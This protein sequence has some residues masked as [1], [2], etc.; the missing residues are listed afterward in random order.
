MART[1]RNGGWSGVYRVVA[2]FAAVLMLTA[3]SAQ[4]LVAQGSGAWQALSVYEGLCR[5]A[6][7]AL[8]MLWGMQA[9]EEGKPA[10]SGALGGLALP[11]FCLLVIWGALYAV[12][13][14]LL[15][16]GALSWP[17][18][19]GALKSAALGQTHFHL[20]LLYPLI[21][22]Y[23]IHP[24]LHRF[25]A[26]ASRGEVRYFLILCFVFASLLPVW[27]AFHPDDAVG[28]LLQRL[29]IH[30]VLGYVGYYVAG[31]YLQHYTIGRV[32]ELIL[33]VLG[34]VGMVV[35]LAGDKLL[36]GGRALWYRDTAPGVALTAVALCALFRYVLGVSEERA[37]RRAVHE[38]GSYVFG[39]YLVHQLWVLAF[40]WFGVPALPF[41]PVLSV[42]MF[43][44][45]FFLLSVPVAWLLRLIPG[46]GRWLV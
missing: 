38:L 7:P 2:V 44:A 12:V 34:I 17:G 30:L 24:V 10:L 33:Y 14:H 32:A 26:S 20:W 6:V 39:A 40:G 36:G 13:S 8:F 45:V 46:V 1:E 9:L 41:G 43:A 37:R 21:G 5:W 4:A 25:T 3:Q 22:L 18:V 11:A 15:G 42:P 28:G 27:T 29:Q 31:W 19:W 35:T 23:L 16:G